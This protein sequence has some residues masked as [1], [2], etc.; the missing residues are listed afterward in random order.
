M[1]AEPVPLSKQDDNENNEQVVYLGDDNPVTVKPSVPRSRGPSE[2]KIKTKNSAKQ[3]QTKKQ[4]EPNTKQVKR[5]QKG[6]L[7]KMKEKYKDQ[8]EEERKLR[9]DILQSSGK[10]K[11]SKKSKKKQMQILLSEKQMKQKE[12]RTARAME[13]KI[14]DEDDGEEVQVSAEVDMLDSLTGIPLMED[15]LLF[16]VPVVAP[17]NTLI[18][19]K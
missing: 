3:Q 7:K 17:Y 8:D 1:L 11:E 5:G 6:K 10:S 13:R 2:S 12:A 18:N 9:M 15:E 4:D 16:S 14:N 19:Y